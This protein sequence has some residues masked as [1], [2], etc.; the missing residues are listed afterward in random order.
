MIQQIKQKLQ[1]ALVAVGASIDVNEL[2]FHDIDSECVHF[3]RG[4]T[5]Y[6]FGW[7]F[8]EEDVHLEFLT[9]YSIE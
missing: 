6:T 3:L 2:E 9:K 4:M 8:D 7:Y 5:V 1:A